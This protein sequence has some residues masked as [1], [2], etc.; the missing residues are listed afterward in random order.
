M[1]KKQSWMLQQLADRWGCCHSSVL[2]LVNKGELRALDISTN[3]SKRSRYI[4]LHEDLE[5][6]EE[7]RTVAPPERPA[8]KRRRVRVPA[9]ETI[10][11]F[12][13]R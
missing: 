8:P 5:A 4:V 3:P 10:E 6:F 2:T 7:A 13:E 1:A 11:F 12:S 9:G